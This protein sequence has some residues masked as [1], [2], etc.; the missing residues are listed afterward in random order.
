ML[1]MDMS[2][3]D[4]EAQ[5]VLLESKLGQDAPVYEQVWQIPTDRPIFFFNKGHITT[6]I[7]KN[8]NTLVEHYQALPYKIQPKSRKKYDIFLGVPADQLARWAKSE[9]LQGKL[10]SGGRDLANVIHGIVQQL[11]QGYNPD[12]IVLMLTA[13]LEGDVTEEKLEKGSQILDMFEDKIMNTRKQNIAAT[14]FCEQ[15]GDVLRETKSMR[16]MQSLD[17]LRRYY[18]ALRNTT[19]KTTGAVE[20]YGRYLEGLRQFLE[21]VY[22]TMIEAGLVTSPQ[23]PEPPNLDSASQIETPD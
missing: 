8:L 3:Q 1:E 15:L 14:A 22:T 17:I 21:N 23:P 12:N 16:R 18:R 20:L 19:L 4:I 10:L 13:A 9:V 5:W 6:Q 11:D 2:P 7:G